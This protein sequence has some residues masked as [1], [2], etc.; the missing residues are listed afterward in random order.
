MSRRPSLS[1]VRDTSASSKRVPFV[2]GTARGLI[3]GALT[4]AASCVGDRQTPMEPLAGGR[5]RSL[6]SDGAHNGPPGFFF[7]QPLVSHPGGSGA[8]ANDIAF[9]NPGVALCDLPDRLH[10]AGGAYAAGAA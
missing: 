1:P 8:P 6:I 3:I 4:L 9:V 7:L 2:H 10:V 5:P